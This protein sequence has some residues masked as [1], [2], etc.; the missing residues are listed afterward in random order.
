MQ[1]TWAIAAQYCEHKET[2]KVEHL[3]HHTHKHDS[4]NDD[5][6]DKVD[7][8]SSGDSSNFSVDTDCPYCHLGSIKSM[9]ASLSV[10]DSN[11]TPVVMVDVYDSY[12]EII[13][14]KPER[15]NWILAV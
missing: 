12:P 3:G 6:I 13:P 5:V 4:E 14:L 10:F 9:V 11:I 1:S 2:P 15:P 8:N 7:Q